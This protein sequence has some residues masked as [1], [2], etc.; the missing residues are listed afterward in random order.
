MPP[1]TVK[2]LMNRGL[3]AGRASAAILAQPA[4]GLERTI[5]RLSEWWDVRRRQWHYD[6]TDVCEEQLQHRLGAAPS[7]DADVFQD[8]WA[9]ALEDLR[10]RGLAAGRGAFGG[11]DDGDVRLGRLAWYLTRNLQPERV[12]ETGVARGL[13][14]RII[15]EAMERNGRGHLWSIDLPPLIEH[16]LSEET[17]AAVPASLKHRWT[18]LTGSSR[19][20]LPQLVR[21]L[22]RVELF[23]HDSMHTT[24]NLRF[25]LDRIWPALAPGG[26]ALVDD[27][28]K[29]RGT[30]DFLGSHPDADGI[31][32]RA[33]DGRALI[34]VLIKRGRAAQ[35]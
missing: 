34:G 1:T 5:E 28:E 3:Y 8:V 16:E 33:E 19:R 2:R 35:S 26:A 32:C 20:R 12:I 18:L 11:W 7:E 29:N 22:S 10:A 23:V 13:T 14:T 31:V 24:R 4:E 27:V 17:A 15:L 30:A 21:Q 9:T 6:A 25:E